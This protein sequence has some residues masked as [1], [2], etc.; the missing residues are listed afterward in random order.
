MELYINYDTTTVCSKFD[1]FAYLFSS[2]IYCYPKYMELDHNL[3]ISLT[4]I[5]SFSLDDDEMLS[6]LISTC[7]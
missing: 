1:V 4:S 3:V 7:L 6:L 5:D 2:I